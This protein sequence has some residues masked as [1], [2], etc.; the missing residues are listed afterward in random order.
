[1]TIMKEIPTNKSISYHDIIEGTTAIANRILWRYSKLIKKY[2][3]NQLVSHTM[4]TEHGRMDVQGH[5][6]QMRKDDPI[7]QQPKALETGN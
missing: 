5:S 3:K 7:I 2:G 4:S 6:Q 1:M